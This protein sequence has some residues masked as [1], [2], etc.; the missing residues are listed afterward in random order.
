MVDHIFKFEEYLNPNNYEEYEEDRD[1]LVRCARCGKLIPPRSIRC[2]Q[3]KVH[4]QGEAQD[5]FHESEREENVRSSRTWIVVV[6]MLLIATFIVPF[7][8]QLLGIISGPPFAR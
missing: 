8:L 6:A 3:C 4:F 2:P 1:T 7:I 5:F